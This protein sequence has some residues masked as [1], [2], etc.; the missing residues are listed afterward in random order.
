MNADPLSSP[1]ARDSSDPP[2]ADDADAPVPAAPRRVTP[3]DEPELP[4]TD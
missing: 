4:F 1:P 3:G 2:Q